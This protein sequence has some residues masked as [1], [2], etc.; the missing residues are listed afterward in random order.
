MEI[1]ANKTHKNNTP[2][3]DESE[4]KKQNKQHLSSNNK[5]SKIS[6]KYLQLIENDLE[7]VHFIQML[8]SIAEE[9]EE[10]FITINLQKKT[11][12]K[13][14]RNYNNKE[15]ES[16]GEV[17][18]NSIKSAI[19]GNS[20]KK[21]RKLDLVIS[22][23]YQQLEDQTKAEGNAAD[24]INLIKKES[25][26]TNTISN[27]TNNNSDTVNNEDEDEDINLE[28]LNKS[29][30]N[31][32]NDQLV[33]LFKRFKSDLDGKHQSIK[34]EI[35]QIFNDLNTQFSYQIDEMYKKYNKYVSQK[36]SEYY[37]IH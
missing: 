10:D 18:Y 7:N 11:I 31:F 16:L 32:T 17:I 15:E 14:L 1:T 25:Q 3:I 37:K 34:F 4:D 30:L 29:D 35:D 24:I 5:K 12:K 9:D 20:N 22:S 27:N 2:N 28:N 13:L 21:G 6:K 36:H 19:K 33:K 23:A 26:T 8:D